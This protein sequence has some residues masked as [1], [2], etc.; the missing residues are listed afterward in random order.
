MCN[1]NVPDWAID[2]LIAGFPS[3][4]LARHDAREI[5]SV[6]VEEGC[7]KLDNEAQNLDADLDWRIL[8]VQI[9]KYVSS[10]DEQFIPNFD[11]LAKHKNDH[12]TT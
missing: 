5:L 6:L 3:A 4:N 2:Q 10:E 9:A 7:L 1:S 11:L 8:A 12:A